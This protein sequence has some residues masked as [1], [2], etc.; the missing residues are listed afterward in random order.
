MFTYKTPREFIEGYTDPLIE[1]LNGTPVYMGGDQTTSPVLSLDNPPTHPTDNRISFFTGEG[2]YKNTRRYGSW[3]DK[4]TIR[5]Q[6]KDYVSI[7]E[8]YNTTFSPWEEE[9]H[10]DGTDGMQFSPSLTDD[11]ILGAFVNDLSRNCYF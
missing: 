11:M 8:L 10:L 2:N 6:K 9:V 1:K 7:N 5:I 3:L 4:D